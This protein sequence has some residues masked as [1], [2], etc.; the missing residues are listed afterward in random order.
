M[1]PEL[2]R[3]LDGELSRD[4]LS[5]EAAADLAA[6]ERLQLA[7]AHVRRE[8][9]P[10]W[11]ADA[12]MRDIAEADS[13]IPAME[14]GAAVDAVQTGTRS[15]RPPARR[16][17]RALVEWLVTPRPMQVR[18]LA[19]LGAALALMLVVLLQGV[20]GDG[21]GPVAGAPDGEP[22]IYVQFALTAEGAQSVAVAGDFNDWSVEAGTLRDTDGSGTWRGLI[23]VQPGVHK[24]MFVVDGE[25]WVTDPTADRFVDDGFGMRNALLAVSLPGEAL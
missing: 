13:Q 15:A 8:T 1:H 4:A 22:V 21:S 18:P 3:Y 6:W 23:A 10:D 12:V 19:P 17:V 2:Q 9:A 25:E 14:A 5:P 7:D 16:G 20:Q 11:L 24:Y